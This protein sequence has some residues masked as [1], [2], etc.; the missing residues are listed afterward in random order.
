MNDDW[1]GTAMITGST[2]KIE[3]EMRE[4]AVRDTYIMR[5][6]GEAARGTWT[7]HGNFQRSTRS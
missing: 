7:L 4:D 1:R 2:R 5:Q 6:K 3:S